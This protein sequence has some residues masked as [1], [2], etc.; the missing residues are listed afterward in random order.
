MAEIIE[1]RD[2][3]N[4]PSVRVGDGGSLVSVKVYQDVYHQVTGRTEQIRKR[5]SQN[6]L[7][8]LSEIEQ[9]HHKIMQLCDVHKIVA[10]NEV[11]SVFHDKERKEQFT[12]FDRFSAYNAN[13]PSP[14]V[15][16]V[17]KY[18]FSIIPAGLD[19][20]QEYVVTV[21][22]TSRVA[23][24]QQIESEAPPFVR[25]RVFS[26]MAGNTAEVTIDY[27]DY[28]VARGF[29]EAFDEWIRGC[30][31][32]PDIS[33]IVFLQRWSHLI[34]KSAKLAAATVIAF[35]ALR[36]APTFITSSTDPQLWARFLIFFGGGFYLITT[37][38]EA[39]GSTIEEAI[40]GYTVISYL[41]L[42]KGDKK[43]ISE[44]SK[45]KR[46]TTL[47]FVFGCL[48]TLVLGIV[49]SKIADII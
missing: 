28:V 48:L 7:I 45:R 44:F 36:A 33:W 27:A 32:E 25:G 14:T 31:S 20:P 2:S 43:L 39:A 1:H 26:F 6:L 42:N 38:A 40:D 18:N 23:M 35:F 41:N 4:P 24:L 29:L 34:P 10:K 3:G 5:Y 12:S 9:L 19:K 16:V 37:L 8:E 30:K 49:S 15:N 47:K 11:V 17:L 22:L 21:R 46:R 13:A